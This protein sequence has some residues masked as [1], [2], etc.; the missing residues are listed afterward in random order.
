MTT[1]DTVWRPTQAQEMAGRFA[2]RRDEHDARLRRIANNNMAP[3]AH[4]ALGTGALPYVQHLTA[5]AVNHQAEMLG[6]PD[7][8][9]SCPV[10]G[11]GCVHA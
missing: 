5:I 9:S 3:I 1:T 10:C 11:I 7:R 6:V 8:I 4:T 2:S